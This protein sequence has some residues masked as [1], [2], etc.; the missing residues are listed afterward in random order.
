MRDRVIDDEQQWL[1]VNERELAKDANILSCLRQSQ[2][3]INEYVNMPKICIQA[4]LLN[5]LRQLCSCV[6]ACV[7]VGACVYE[8]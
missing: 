3:V 1:A 5:I 2:I 8:T 4:F 6:R 7:G